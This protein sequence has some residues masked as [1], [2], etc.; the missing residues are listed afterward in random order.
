MMPIRWISDSK[1]GVKNPVPMR[2]RISS[3]EKNLPSATSSEGVGGMS[4]VVRN[5]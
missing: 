4:V 5:T 1:L 2:S 3:K